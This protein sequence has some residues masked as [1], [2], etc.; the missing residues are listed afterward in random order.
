MINILDYDINNVR[1]VE[2]VL[3]KIGVPSR[4]VR[5]NNDLRGLNNLIIPGIGSYDAAMSTLLSRNLV[6][7][8]NDLA[9]D[10]KIPILGVCLGMQLMAYTS[11]EGSLP[12]LGWFNAHVSKLSPLLPH[13]RVPNMG[14][15]HIDI[16]KEHLCFPT[17]HEIEYKFYF[18]HSYAVKCNS[19]SD[20]LA[21]NMHSNKFAAAIA[22][23]NLIGVQFHPEKSHHF[24][25]DF[26]RNFLKFI[27]VK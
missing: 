9:L 14:W 17:P 26:F 3:S 20:I 27:E 18:V 19:Q 7:P 22:K 13:F 4:I 24:G 15:S 21:I 6:G 12:G 11:E 1:S 8:L 23:D 5:T 16:V 2:K 10:K 25:Q